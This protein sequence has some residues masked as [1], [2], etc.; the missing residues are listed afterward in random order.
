MKVSSIL[1]VALIAANTCQRD[2]H[3]MTADDP[4]ADSTVAALDFDKDIKPVLQSHCMPCHF[5]GGKMYEKMPFDKAQTLL[6]HQEGIVK[7]IKDPDE[8]EKLKAFL[9]QQK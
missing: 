9:E 1:L 6:D 4:L 3:S 2:R 8:A 5:T 7:R